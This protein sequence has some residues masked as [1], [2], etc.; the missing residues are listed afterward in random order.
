LIG[1]NLSFPSTEITDTLQLPDIADRSPIPIDALQY[2][3]FS[4]VI[5][6]WAERGLSGLLY[7]AS[8]PD[9]E[10]YAQEEIDVAQASGE[11]II[12]LLA[13]EQMTKRLMDIQRKRTSDNLINDLRMRRALHDVILP[14][15]HEIII[16]LSSSRRDENS[17]EAS[18]KR[19][20][21]IHHDIAE[22]I[23]RPSKQSATDGVQ[24]NLLNALQ[25][26]IDTEFGSSFDQITWDIEADAIHIKDSLATEILLGATRELV[27][28]AALHG[29]GTRDQVLTL[30]VNIKQN[31]SLYV[32][33]TD[34]GVGIAQDTQKSQIGTGSGLALHRALL[35]V[36]GADCIVE[37]A[38][39]QGI[40]STIII[41][42]SIALI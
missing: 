6:L 23:R 12:D 35:A 21:Q 22:L 36:I 14:T 29:R 25:M 16:E 31:A 32:H 8:K 2:G 37:P 13:A 24:S 9:G 42:P 15:L 20:T 5:P 40:R 17:P 4:W 41:P 3:G 10:P 28:N 26:M 19:L 11:R 39:P 33:V 27:R 38:I 18:I 1:T 30:T 7:I 34:D